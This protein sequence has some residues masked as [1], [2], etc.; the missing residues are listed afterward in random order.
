M[1][2]PVMDISDSLLDQSPIRTCSM[3]I[4]VI[5]QLPVVP[6]PG[7]ARQTLFSLVT[8]FQT[9]MYHI[10]PLILLC[11][12]CQLHQARVELVKSPNPRML[13]FVGNSYVCHWYMWRLHHFHV[14]Q[15]LHLWLNTLS[16]A[17]FSTEVSSFACR[18]QLRNSSQSMI[19]YLAF[20]FAW[21]PNSS[22]P[23]P[24]LGF[25]SGCAGCWFLWV[26]LE[27]KWGG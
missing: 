7:S 20:S 4:S 1:I 14:Y 15:N 19:V 24:L 22:S 25:Q 23:E 6:R 26:S 21:H 10:T 16:C 18:F 8:I 3:C 5:Y 17:L 13:N 12:T 9:F 27:R 11:F 2:N